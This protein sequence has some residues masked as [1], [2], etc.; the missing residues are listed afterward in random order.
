MNSIIINDRFVFPRRFDDQEHLHLR[1][2][3]RDLYRSTIDLASVLSTNLFLTRLEVVKSSSHRHGD[4]I[5][6]GVPAVHS[7]TAAISLESY[8]PQATATFS[9]GAITRARTIEHSD[10]QETGHFIVWLGT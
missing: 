4:Q 5:V 1:H 10:L 8:S 9:I 6:I 3:V 2:H 7:E